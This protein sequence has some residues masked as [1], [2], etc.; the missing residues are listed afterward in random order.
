[1]IPAG[2]ERQVTNSEQPTGRGR[3]RALNIRHRLNGMRIELP[4]LHGLGDRTDKS[5]SR[6]ASM[7]DKT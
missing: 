3:A 6:R 4:A 7:S 1:V 5:R 2:L